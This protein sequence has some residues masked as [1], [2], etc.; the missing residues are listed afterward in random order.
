[1]NLT[2]KITL[3]ASFAVYL[4]FAPSA[5]AL[6][7][8]KVYIPLGGED[9]ISIV[10]PHKDQVISKISNLPAIH[11]LAGTPDGQFLVAGSFQEG[12]IGSQMKVKPQGMSEDDHASHH[13]SAPEQ[14][15]GSMDSLVS[16]VSIIRT[17]DN[18][19][20][21]RIDVPGAVH[22]V[23][24]SPDGR[25]SAVTRPKDNAVTII[26]M[27]SYEVV[28][29]IETGGLP[30]YV[31]FRP[32]GSSLF[33]SNADDDTVSSFQTGSWKLNWTIKA[34]ESPEHL[35]VS[36]D[37]ATLYVNNVADGTVSFVSTETG[38]LIKTIAVGSP[39]HGIDL[40]D[41]GKILFVADQGND[42]LVGIDVDNGKIS[43]VLEVA[44]PYHL[45]AIHGTGK[46]YLSSV[47][48]PK[49]WVIDQSTMEIIGEIQING[50]GHQ[51]V[52]G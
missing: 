20:V 34:G 43:N 3:A 49:I 25:F 1:M 2:R 21:R 24:V 18:S 42:R 9:E 7:D 46:L 6:A 10:D 5:S 8:Q 27:R 44:E 41:D 16:T 35:V 48:E 45:T 15:A 52:L 28:A 14:T 39:L 32:D 22:H 40:S 12:E 4:T 37:G 50:K 19:I 38:Q 47:T 30:N 17:T 26:D 11:G 51:M 13:S 36:N 29:N 23:A 31:S 33:V